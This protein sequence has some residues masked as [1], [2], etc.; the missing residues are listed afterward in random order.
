[1][2]ISGPDQEYEI[3]IIGGVV[4]EISKRTIP[5]LPEDE[6]C[7]KEDYIE[8]IF[9]EIFGDDKI[10]AKRVNRFL[11]CEKV[12]LKYLFTDF[13]EIENSTVAFEKNGKIA[14]VP[15]KELSGKDKEELLIFFAT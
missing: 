1:M 15:R 11:I 4:F 13:D 3:S 5:H 14:V 7:V 8:P 2:R 9:R 6:V 12:K 10:T